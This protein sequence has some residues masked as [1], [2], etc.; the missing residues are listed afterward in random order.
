MARLQ[1]TV[2]LLACFA[3][4]AAVHA[5]KLD[6]LASSKDVHLVEFYHPMCGTCT[7]FTPIYDQLTKQLKGQMKVEKVSIESTE[8]EQLAEAVGALEDGIPCVRLFHKAGDKKGTVIMANEEPLPSAAT[9]KKRVEKIL[10][11]KAKYT[12]EEL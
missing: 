11:K 8:G 2:A 12:K 5:L 7:Q 3:A 6:D 1:Q 10:G 4:S 9:L